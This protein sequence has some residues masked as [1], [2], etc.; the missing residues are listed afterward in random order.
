MTTLSIPREALFVVPLLISIFTILGNQVLLRRAHRVQNFFLYATNT[1]E[2][3]ANIIS[4]ILHQNENSPAEEVAHQDQGCVI[5]RIH[6]MLDF[7][8][9]KHTDH[10]RSKS[11]EALVQGKK[12]AMNGAP[13]CIPRS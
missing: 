3:N 8:W 9:R 12:G 13:T 5:T 6:F 10:H 11:P 2:I 7:P 1:V 4:K